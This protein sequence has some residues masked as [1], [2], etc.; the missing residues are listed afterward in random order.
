MDYLLIPCDKISLLYKKY[1]RNDDT[2]YT[3]LNMILFPIRK[4]NYLMLLKHESCM[5]QDYSGAC[6]FIVNTH[7]SSNN[8]TIVP[9]SVYRAGCI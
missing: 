4:V 6:S 5:Y 7:G 3:C 2:H 9:V 1:S 8:A